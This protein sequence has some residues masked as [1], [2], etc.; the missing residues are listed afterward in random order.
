MKAVIW[1][2]GLIL[3]AAAAAMSASGQTLTDY[4][5]QRKKY[6]ITQAAGIQALEVFVG[7]RVIEVQGKIKGT[8]SIDTKHMLLV[9]RSDG[10]NFQI[11]SDFLPDWIG[12]G[13]VPARLLVHAQRVAEGGELQAKLISLAPE[14][15][16]AALE[17][18]AA[19]KAA[20]EKAKRD[21][22][23]PPPKNTLSRGD[24]NKSAENWNL[25]ASEVQPIYAS[26][27]KGRNKRLTDAQANEIA[28]G[29]IGFSIRY[30]VDA[31]LILAMVMVESSFNPNATSSAGAQGLGQLM[32]GTAKSL[33]ITDPYD[34]LQNL[35]GTVRTI[36]G[37][38]DRQ[39]KNSEDAFENLVLALAA[40]NAGSGA[41]RKYNGVPPY[42][43]TQN[44]I[45]K[46]VGLYYS[47]LGKK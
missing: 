15:K 10:L 47:F 5:A 43:Q 29:I 31:R 39:G 35:Y 30:G 6:G 9:E 14:S 37:H 36:R 17:A 28:Q 12:G 1:R 8:F 34:T 32:P 7:K 4:L 11:E 27:I 3:S 19:R 18:E 42:A 33:G 40:Y 25:P 23:R 2:M 45:K 24:I 26:F 38:I 22:K 44:Y 16:I 21:A 13:V 46:V 41:V 20:E